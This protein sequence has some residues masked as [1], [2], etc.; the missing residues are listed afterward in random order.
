M[1]IEWMDEAQATRKI[2]WED[3]APQEAGV[4]GA[5]A[6]TWPARLAQGIYDMATNAVTPVG[7]VVTG[8]RADVRSADV[9][10]D[11]G[12]VYR[13]GQ[14]QGNTVLQGR[15]D[16]EGMADA[17]ML[18]SPGS[19]GA[20]ARMAAAPS[21]VQ[22]IT[23][24]QMTEGGQ[25]VDAGQRIGVD[26]PR[27]AASDN[28]AIQSVGRKVS[29]LPFIGTPLR[30]SAQQS[31]SQMDDAVRN[32]QSAYGD[33]NIGA[34][35]ADLRNAVTKTAT[36]TL[37]AKV[38]AQYDRVDE[39][40]NP[41]LK[42]PI[43]KTAE[44]SQK[45]LS[46]LSESGVNGSKAVDFV[47][48]AAT[49]EGLTYQ[50]IKG[51]RTRIGEMLKNPSLLPAN[52]SQTELGRIY[53][54]LSDDLNNAVRQSGGAAAVAFE[55]ANRY[56]ARVAKKRET[57]QKIVNVQKD[58][59]LVYKIRDLASTGRSASSQQLRKARAAVDADTWDDLA[60]SVLQDM[61][62]NVQ[63]GDF[64]PARFLTE[65]GKLSTAG[66][67]T[68]FGSTGK[69]EMVSNLNDL[70]KV[71]TRF[72]ELEKFANPSGSGAYVATALA[73]P[74]AYIEPTTFIASAI[75]GSAFAR[76]M[77]KPAAVKYVTQYSKA[78]LAYALD[79]RPGTKSLLRNRSAVLATMLSKEVDGIN[80]ALF[81]DQLSG[82]Q[83]AVAGQE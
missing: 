24:R 49:R 5:L 33:G 14:Y 73:A 62:R 76:I 80:P 40:V 12:D 28:M 66:K 60:A 43:S 15:T 27:A 6:T 69:R 77:A 48:E 20:K 1:P 29:D 71:A 18:F 10:T 45:I 7:D 25:A 30:K 64:S 2:E 19:A 61:G 59:A 35:G 79:P 70:A 47:M 54:S 63:T 26:L 21:P 39:L 51:L 46:E 72:N 37:P 36:E 65:W 44:E 83:D 13:D 22:R 8:N 16:V 4:M 82:S 34:A 17:A 50:G 41:T 11:A 78:K 53:A 68:L 32:V 58:E 81:A 74:F 52:T 56:A 38:S 55:R 3:E 75:G 57:L 23:P 9:L 42:V 31:I 67:N